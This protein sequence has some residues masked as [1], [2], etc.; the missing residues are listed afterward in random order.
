MQK[1]RY[2]SIVVGVDGSESAT[3]VVRWAAAEAAR[4]GAPLRLVGVFVTAAP[5]KSGVVLPEGLF[6]Y[7]RKDVARRLDSAVAVA[8]SVSAELD[9]RTEVREGNPAHELRESSRDARLLVL[10]SR[11]LSG[12]ARI[13]AGSVSTALVAHATCPVVVLNDD[14]EEGDGPVVVG[15]DGSSTSDSAVAVAF[16]E[17]SVRGAELVA[18]HAWADVAMDFVFGYGLAA[19][20]W[21]AIEA[22]QHQLIAER[23]ADLRRQYPD[24]SVRQV[25][26]QDRPVRSLI[27]HGTGAQLLVVG[28]RGRGG[29]RGMLLGSTSRALLHTAPCPLLVARVGT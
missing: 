9:V 13:M 15:V 25:V 18:V 28:S 14:A 27:E 10:G 1:N 21:T 7:Q 4:T 26:L 6:E 8:G 17:A 12:F 3:R 16:Q 22:E 2:G 29:L 24:V 11:G 20:D 23:L 5:A 19:E